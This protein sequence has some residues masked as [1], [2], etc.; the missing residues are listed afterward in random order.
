MSAGPKHSDFV[1]A[2]AVWLL[3]AIFATAL[4]GFYNYSRIDAEFEAEART[5]HRILSQR[6]DQHDAHLTSLAAVV[7]DTDHTSSTTRAIADAVLRFY[8]RITAIEVVVLQ[9]TT[10]TVF[11]TRSR[12]W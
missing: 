11:T 8:P 4:L 12:G 2:A 9:P 5:I 3:F 1:A 6:A 10:R 7:S